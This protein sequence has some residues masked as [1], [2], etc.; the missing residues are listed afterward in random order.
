MLSSLLIV[1]AFYGYQI[2]KKT[3]LKERIAYSNAAI[4]RLILQFVGPEVQSS[5]Y[6]GCR[7]L[8]DY[9]PVNWVANPSYLPRDKRPIYGFRTTPGAC[10]SNGMP[11]SLCDR[12]EINSDLIILYNVPQAYS[13]LAQAVEPTMDS[14]LTQNSKGFNQGALILI[15][16]CLQGDLFEA[17]DIAQN[18]IFHYERVRNTTQYLSKAY[19]L[20]AEV[21][22]LNSF[23]YYLGR[24]A[25]YQGNQRNE[26]ALY[27]HDFQQGKSKEIV[28]G[29]TKF[30]VEYGLLDPIRGMSYRSAHEIPDN[31]WKM[32]Q[33]VRI[34][35]NDHEY[36]FTI[37]NRRRVNL[38]AYYHN[39]Y[40][41]A[42]CFD[43][44]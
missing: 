43:N 13:S 26:Y 19:G 33:T 20:D 3:Y 9:F 34:T 38:S 31:A 4:A 17:D 37:R 6:F 22:R 7:T 28:G 30:K 41:D 36:E 44:A 16:D 18:R 35:V 25:R 10:P 27:R 11:Q 24:P 1:S 23:A 14:L 12:V 40:F 15:S 5:G 39:C 42:G 32:I 8:D 21:V 29:I 2:I